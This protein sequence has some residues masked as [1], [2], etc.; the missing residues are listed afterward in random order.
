MT[1]AQLREAEQ[2]LEARIKRCFDVA[3]SKIFVM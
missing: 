1:P 2:R 3:V